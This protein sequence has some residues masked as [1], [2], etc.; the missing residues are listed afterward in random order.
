M[1]NLPQ[2]RFWRFKSVWQFELVAVIG[3]VFLAIFAKFWEPGVGISS[4]TYGAIA[5]N[6]VEDF[7]LFLPHLAPGIYDP[8]VEHPYLVIWLNSF[9]F[10]LFGASAQT[11]RVVSSIFCLVT[12]FSLFKV[13]ETFVSK[14]ASVAA[15]ILLI[16]VNVFMNFASSGWLDMP[17]IG[18]CWFGF[19]LLSR[20]TIQSISWQHFIGLIFLG[21]AVLAKGLSAI[22]V[23]PIFLWYVIQQRDWKNRLSACLLVAFPPAIFAFF[24]YRATGFFFWK[25]YFVRQVLVQNNLDAQAHSLENLLWYLTD[26]IRFGHVVFFIGLAGCWILLRKPAPAQ[27][28]LSLLILSEVLLHTIVYSGSSRHFSQYVIPV[29]PWLAL[30]GSVVFIKVFAKF[31]ALRGSLYLLVFSMVFFVL[32]DLLPL[33]IHSGNENPFRAMKDTIHA[34]ANKRKSYFVGSIDDQNTWE[35]PASYIAWY[36]DGEPQI[37]S[38]ETLFKKIESDGGFGILKREERKLLGDFDQ[39]IIKICI[40]NKQLLVFTKIAD[41]PESLIRSREEEATNQVFSR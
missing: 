30:A 38:A 13:T 40:E 14:N 16:S 6:M 34:L 20:G 23:V 12:F 33:R 28:A 24:H 15:A 22:A 25:A 29:F 31:Q 32:V 26:L 19:Y 5:K 3:A 8:F 4:T 2:V 39:N 41:C 35:A 1:S 27:R 11:I 17:M 21:L 36:W 37:S 18:L 7:K 9:I 10:F